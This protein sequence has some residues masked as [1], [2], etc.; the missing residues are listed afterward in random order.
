MAGRPG[1]CALPN[2]DCNPYMVASTHV[3]PTSEEGMTWC[4]L[5]VKDAPSNETK[6]LKN[7]NEL[8]L[9][10]PKESFNRKPLLTWG[11]KGVPRQGTS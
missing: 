9:Q 1:G 11:E 7:R 5:C 2:K 10:G 6:K 8:V 4:C 3:M